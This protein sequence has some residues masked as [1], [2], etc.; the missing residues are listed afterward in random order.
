[1]Y[2]L[3]ITILSWTGHKTC[4]GSA[5]TVHW[6]CCLNTERDPISCGKQLSLLSKVNGSLFPVSGRG[7]ERWGVG[8]IDLGL[9]PTSRPNLVVV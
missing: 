2:H 5:C 9:L 4:I 7:V 6:L 3:Y 1:M 8:R